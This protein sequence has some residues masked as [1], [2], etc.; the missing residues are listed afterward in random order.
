MNKAVLAAVTLVLT[1]ALAQAPLVVG[2]DVSP[3]RKPLFCTHDAYNVI[4]LQD[5]ARRPVSLPTQCS[6]RPGTR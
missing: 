3:G 1:S 2:G 4:P 6:P 5:A